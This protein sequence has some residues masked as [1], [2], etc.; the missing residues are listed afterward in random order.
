MDGRGR[1]GRCGVRDGEVEG[2]RVGV[3]GGAEGGVREGELCV[4][5]DQR[6]GMS[7]GIW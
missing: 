3:G 1:R 7:K 4:K 6:G 5:M 2:E